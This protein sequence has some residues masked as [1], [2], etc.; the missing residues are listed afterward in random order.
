MLLGVGLRAEGD[1]A[2]VLVNALHEW[3][4]RSG[5]SG[6]HGIQTGQCAL[7]LVTLRLDSSQLSLE[8]F[9]LLLAFLRSVILGRLRLGSGGSGRA[10]IISPWVVITAL[11][12]GKAE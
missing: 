10:R 7:L 9:D 6:E 4:D 11:G 2:L 5:L 3:I 12:S 8:R 1:R